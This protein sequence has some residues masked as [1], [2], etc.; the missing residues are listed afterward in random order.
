MITGRSQRSG[1]DPISAPKKTFQTE[2]A[3]FAALTVLA[4]GA[5]AGVLG[6]DKFGSSGES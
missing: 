1:Y 2:V 3:A 6:L 4:A 5:A